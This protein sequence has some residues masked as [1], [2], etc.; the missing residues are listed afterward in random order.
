M[1]KKVLFCSDCKYPGGDAPS[2]YY[3]NVGR[4]F[5]KEGYITDFI[6]YSDF[7]FNKFTYIKSLNGNLI[8]NKTFNGNSLLF[9]ILNNFCLYKK[10]TKIIKNYG[11][12]YD[13]F[14]FT[15]PLS[16]RLLNRFK[17]AINKA[18]SNAKIFISLT[19]EYDKSEFETVNYFGR[20]RI[21]RNKY[22]VNNIVD[23]RIKYVTISKFLFNKL[24]KRGL[25]VFYLP[26]IFDDALFVE[27]NHYSKEKVSFIYAGNPSNKDKVLMMLEGF[28]SL[29]NDIKTKVTLNLIG[30][31]R[32]WLMKRDSEKSIFE[33]VKSF[34]NFYGV[35][36]NDFVRETYA[37]SDFSILLRDPD[38]LYAKAGFPTKV[39]ESFS[40][41][42]PVISNITS[43]LEDYLIDGIN[44]IVVE[45]YS[46]IAFSKSIKK[47]IELSEQNSKQLKNGAY[48]TGLEKLSVSVISP[49]FIKFVQEK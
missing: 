8:S 42:T 23:K 34:T 43:N 31:D 21:R 27:N 2:I 25:P 17:R 36:S 26:F 12:N 30:I 46:S 5:Q 11:S 3:S 40:C 13:I 49:D 1:E 38:A 45:S 22:L 28:A 24:Y 48:K 6:G 18:N 39:V 19:E 29:D 35:K 7:S 47:A 33:G 9:K 16:N 14:Y 15:L 4:A 32:D 41:G 44:S 20:L 10:I 37:N